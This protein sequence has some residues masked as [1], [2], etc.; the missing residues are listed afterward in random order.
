[1]EIMSAGN[2]TMNSPRRLHPLVAGAAVTVMVFSALGIAA[3]TGILPGA[4]S[5]KSAE[6]TPGPVQPAAAACPS[7]GTVESIRSVEVRGDATGVGAVAGGVTGAVVGHQ[8]GNGRGNTAMT[9]LG[10]A[11]GAYAGNEIEKNVKKHVVYRVTVKMDDGSFRTVSQAA[12]PAFA[13]GDKVRVVQGTLRA[14]K[15]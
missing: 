6:A 14:A 4:M 11:G 10:A 7:C 13:V 3:I 15:S 2:G 1:V 5:Q 9:V 12:E 8:L